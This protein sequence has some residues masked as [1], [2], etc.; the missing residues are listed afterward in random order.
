MESLFMR[1]KTKTPM[2]YCLFFILLFLSSTNWAQSKYIIYG[3]VSNSDMA[4]RE[5]GVTIKITS[6]GSPVSTIVTSNS[7]KFTSPLAYGK[8]YK[9]EFSKPGLIS[10]FLYVDLVG[11]NVEDVP[12]G[13]LSQEFEMSLFG[14]I[15]G[16]DLSFLQTMPTTTF[17]LNM[18][19]MMSEYDRK[20]ADD[21]RAKI[22]A[23]L[24]KK[25]ALKAAQEEKLRQYEQLMTSG[26][27]NFA[28]LKYDEALKNYQAASAILPAEAL[29][30]EKIAATNAKI[31]ELND[32]KNQ[33]A[34]DAQY[35]A[36]IQEADK[37]FVAKDWVKAQAKYEEAINLKPDEQHP[38]Q[39]LI[40]IEEIL[41]NIKKAELAAKQK[42]E[43]YTNLITAAD[44]LRKQNQLENAKAKYNE[45]I[46]I[47][48]EQYPKDQIIAIDL[49]I[50]KQAE[51]AKNNEAYL[52]AMKAADLL[53]SQSKLEE[54]LA[55]YKEATALKPSEVTPKEKMAEITKKIADLAAQKAKDKSY[56]DAIAAADALFGQEK[57]A[58]AKLN[59][60][61]ALGIKPDETYPKTKI[62][63][64]ELKIKELADK[65]LTD[66]AYNDKITAADVKFNTNAFDE[67]KKLYQEASGLK[68]TEDYPKSK[69]KEIETKL[70]AQ[71]KA[72][73]ENEKYDQLI[74]EANLLYAGNKLE[75]AK[76]K[77][78]EAS[79]VKPAETLPKD[80]IAEITKKI[81]D[82]A[83]SQ[84]LESDYTAAITQGQTYLTNNDF[85]KA[86]AQYE[87]AQSLKPT[88][89][90]PKDKL[91]EIVAKIAAKEK[92]DILDKKYADLV[93]AADN[94]FNTEKYSEA[95]VNYLEA[96]QIKQDP[97]LDGRIKA[98][99][100]KLAEI[101]TQE[102]QKKAYNDKIILADN[103]FGRG[104]LENAKKLYEE[105]LVIDVSQTYPKDKIKEIATAIANKQSQAERDQKFSSLVA[106]ADQLSSDKKLEQAVAKYEEAIAVKPDQ[107]VQQ[108][109]T[110]LQAQINL[111]KG[112][113]QKDAEYEAALN[114]AQGKENGG[115]LV[116]A[117][118]AYKKAQS[119]KPAEPLPN[120]KITEIQN[121]LQADQQNA[122]IT[123]QFNQAIKEGDDLLNAGQYQEAKNKY[124]YAGTIKNDP[125][126][127]QKIA[128]AEQKM[129]D[130]STA[131]VEAN[132]QKIINKANEL[133]S[134]KDWENAIKYYERALS[135]KPD[136]SIPK[137]AI[138][139]IRNIQQEELNKNAAQADIEKRYNDAM[140]LGNQKMI[141]GYLT[142]ALTAFVNAKDIK[143]GDVPAQNKINEVNKLIQA[144]MSLEQ[145]NT[146][147]QKFIQEGDKLALAFNYENAILSYQQALEF[148]PNDAIAQ[149]KIAEA[150]AQIEKRKNADKNLLYNEWIGKANQAFVAENYEAAMN[151][152]QEALKIKP[153]DKL[154]LDKI[155]E[156]RQILD[157]IA[158]QK[159]KNNE[160]EKAYK[161]FISDADSKFV[162]ENW[163]DAQ[164][165]YQQALGVK[166]NDSY[167]KNQLQATIDKQEAETNKMLEGQYAKILAKG[168]DYFNKEN[169]EDAKRMYERALS[170]K[171]SDQYPKDKIDE[172]ARIMANGGKNEIHLENLG[173]QEDISIMDGEALIAKA[174]IIRKS[175]KNERILK[176]GE[177]SYEELANLS[178][179]NRRR[180]L[181]NNQI[182]DSILIKKA[183]ADVDISGLQNDIIKKVDSIQNKAANEE[184]I[185]G[186]YE[187]NSALQTSDYVNQVIKDKSVLDQKGQ[188][189]PK[190]I[191]AKVN[192]TM[193]NIENKALNDGS[194]E[195]NNAMATK[196]HLNNVVLDKETAD[197]KSSGIRDAVEAQI[198]DI[199]TKEM[200]KSTADLE[201]EYKDLK[202]A[203]SKIVEI[204]TEKD[205]NA[206]NQSEI[207]Q[208]TNQKVVDLNSQLA[209]NAAK[210][211]NNA[212]QNNLDIQA[213][214]VKINSDS[215]IESSQQ[216]D[217]RQEIIKKVD[218]LQDNLA[219][220]NAVQQTKEQDKI[221]RTANELTSIADEKELEE[222]NQSEQHQQVV[223][224]VKSVEN[225]QSKYEREQSAENKTS[226]LTTNQEIE[227]VTIASEKNV[228]NKGEIAKNNAE[229]VTTISED[230]SKLQAEKSEQNMEERRKLTNLLDQLDAK[231]IQFNETIAN[232][233]A[234]QFPA[235]I[236]EENY[237]L[238]DDE[239]LLISMMT[240]RIVVK[241][242]RGDVY[243]KSTSRAGTT[244]S[245]NGTPIAEAIWAKETQDAK[246]E[247]H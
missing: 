115:D 71:A 202:A 164:K 156:I 152:Y 180:N 215:E 247:K 45:A 153:D 209:E 198:E 158:A 74:S 114:L 221:Q 197:S 241:D 95:K 21:M 187:Y 13:D 159:N 35:N 154:T 2:R 50:K 211:Q 80:K 9:I 236:T 110:A 148:K 105:A 75:E 84:K 201:K 165:L 99:D 147:Y 242:G 98:I 86:K 216:D 52:A 51:E 239:G 61:K 121:K 14:E 226:I 193:V 88:E 210:E 229:K 23:V 104:E 184:L 177:T 185:N 130:E 224:V 179:K 108:K 123:K 189:I 183:I 94:F 143:P 22:D 3:V 141:N 28:G 42:D 186:T 166:P 120:Q 62:A 196:E 144:K 30:K 113:A 137:N 237:P 132:Y 103:A 81:A 17:T 155:D 67:A 39:R 136:D 169:W 192:T 100:D 213:K 44:N 234:E 160:T 79:T 27:Q 55:K 171:S 128:L 227:N 43:Q 11:I 214:I 138:A 111:L 4:R 195:Y 126:V 107:G 178:R 172:I 77:Y 57:F 40:E 72:K 34:K 59:Y 96:K 217:S 119:I 116:A 220:A 101:A 56:T 38:T 73:L 208:T 157:N 69:I 109:I 58:D 173:R 29:P 151:L 91:A 36:A 124:V 1:T 48:A 92:Q 6:S 145:E 83:A 10:R 97:Y 167:A 54:A 204:Q 176:R 168:D 118:A 125:I 140:A 53:Y 20:Q 66:K 191:A 64:I 93:T 18:K 63:E 41:T 230:A 182:V 222:T 162:K 190:N 244:Y 78:T 49:L 33:A 146:K 68:P 205:E 8:K 175:R 246:L 170:L 19:K 212:R 135:M 219:D 89:V 85:L 218:E 207:L 15:P 199:Q 5:P 225:E 200:N 161:A 188:E 12:A 203:N 243:L 163:K 194:D 112:Q 233:L 223:D 90:L 133:K 149:Q 240:R 60:Q 25:D 47:K 16:A 82:L 76:A 206:M 87:I 245:K 127:P 122:A 46:A 26:D 174:E 235:G 232:S 181:K 70:A 231:G 142:D 65:Q 24:A 238:Y 131:Q 117:L 150:K 106:Q 37:A 31:K 32:Q 134:Q 7:G 139:E 102:A 129:K 228:G